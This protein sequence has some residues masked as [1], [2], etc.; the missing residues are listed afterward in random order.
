[1]VVVVTEHSFM[2]DSEFFGYRRPDATT[3]P[4]DDGTICDRVVH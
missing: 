1:M 2:G 4:E 3:A